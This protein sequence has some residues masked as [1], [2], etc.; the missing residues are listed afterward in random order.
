[1]CVEYDAQVFMKSIMLLE[2]V[3]ML[4]T[5]MKVSPVVTHANTNLAFVRAGFREVPSQ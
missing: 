1:M 2:S 5:T 3:I 4:N